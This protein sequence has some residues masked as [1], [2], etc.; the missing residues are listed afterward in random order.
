VLYVM[1]AS[2]GTYAPAPGE[3]DFV[4]VLTGVNPTATWFADRPARRAG[5]SSVD[6]AIKAIGFSGKAGP[7]N[8]VLELPDAPADQNAT[9]VTLNDPVYDPAAATLQFSV[10]RL[11]K[12]GGLLRGHRRALDRGVAESFGPAGLFID[13]ADAPVVSENPADPGTQGQPNSTPE[14]VLN[15]K[16][17]S[18]DKGIVLVRT[19]ATVEGEWKGSIE[20]TLKADESLTYRNVPH[21][22]VTCGA[23]VGGVV[24][25]NGQRRDDI[26]W[27]FEFRNAQTG[28]STATASCPST[29]TPRLTCAARVNS[30]G[31]PAN[32]FVEIGVP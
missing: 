1:N 31:Q 17:T 5:T 10:Q 18:K 12:V 11:G 20:D 14:C 8:A 32:V 3:D 22:F 16:H 25:I 21:A 7:P 28:A 24:R 30:Y 13:D 19:Y 2:G 9:A 26:T 15:F 29:A 23:H 6:E 4:L 27:Q